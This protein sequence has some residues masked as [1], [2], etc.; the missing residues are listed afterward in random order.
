MLKEYYLT[1][2]CTTPAISGIINLIRAKYKNELKKAQRAAKK[3]GGSVQIKGEYSWKHLSEAIESKVPREVWDWLDA[4]GL[5]NQPHFFMQ[6][7]PDDA[8]AEDNTMDDGELYDAFGKTYVLTVDPRD[9]E[10]ASK[11]Q[12][13]EFEGH[14]ISIISDIERSVKRVQE[15]MMGMVLMTTR[16]HHLGT[17]LLKK[18]MYIL[19]GYDFAVFH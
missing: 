17:V 15:I 19:K 12:R 7:D 11:E 5:E 10:N 16:G 9:H 18:S 2:L 3:K 1:S 6:R 14:I 13:E 4:L 8:K